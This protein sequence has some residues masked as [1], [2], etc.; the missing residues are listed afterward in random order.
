MSGRINMEKLVSICVISYNSSKTIINTLESIKKQTYS[1]IELIIS[2]DG[3]QDNT[4]EIAKDWLEKNKTIFYNTELITVE[5]NTGVTANVNRAIKK[6]QGEF[7]K[8]IAADDD[9]V[10]EYIEKCIKYFESNTNIQVLFT[11]VK[12]IDE[13]GNNVEHTVD[14]DFFKLSAE[15]QFKTIVLHGAP[16]IPTPSIIYRKSVFDKLGLFDERIPMWEDGPYYFTL[17]KN[18]IKLELLE[19][20]LVINGVRSDSLSNSI[21]YRHRKSIAQ[22]YYYDIFKEEIKIK[23]IKALFHR[24]KFW[25]LYHSDK[26]F[27][28]KI[29]NLLCRKKKSI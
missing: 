12:F 10:P 5:K 14:Y 1:P 16:A 29:Y 3:S 7:I 27:Y 8:D 23:P 28:Y 11:K 20:E 21:P 19:E 13:S 6:A 15:E 17:T 22:F 18:G 25:F 24:F 9:L 26:K 2:D 4:I